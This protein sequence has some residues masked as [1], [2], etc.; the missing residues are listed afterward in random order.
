MGTLVFWYINIDL[1]K[2]I[3][4]IIRIK[5]WVE[6]KENICANKRWKGTKKEGTAIKIWESQLNLGKLQLKLENRK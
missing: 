2:F 5:G 6:N 1:K 3:E 4:G